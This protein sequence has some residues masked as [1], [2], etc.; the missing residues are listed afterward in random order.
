PVK[1]KQAAALPSWPAHPRVSSACP[2]S[3][4]ATVVAVPPGTQVQMAA[5]PTTTKVFALASVSAPTQVVTARPAI[6]RPALAH[7]HPTQLIP[8]HRRIQLI[9]PTQLT[10]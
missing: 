6:S 8:P 4:F 10:R 5:A 3:T 1:A 9:R 2:V 7:H